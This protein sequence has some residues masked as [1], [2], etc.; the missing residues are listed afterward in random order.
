MTALGYFSEDI[1][2]ILYNE[3]VDRKSPGLAGLANLDKIC[4]QSADA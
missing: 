1:S 3:Q 2:V 4:A